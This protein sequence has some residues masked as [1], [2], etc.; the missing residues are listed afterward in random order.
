M[1]TFQ[2]DIF[3]SIKQSSKTSKLLYIRKNIKKLL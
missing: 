2:N 1:N 3:R